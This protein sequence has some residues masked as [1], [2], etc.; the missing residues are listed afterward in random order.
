[1][2]VPCQHALCPLLSPWAPAGTESRASLPSGYSAKDQTWCEYPA[3]TF[4]PF[5]AH[6]C[7]LE[8]C[9]SSGEGACG[10]PR[11]A[12]LSG[13]VL[14][15]CVIS[16]RLCRRREHHG[17]HE[18][19][20]YYGERDTDSLVKVRCLTLQERNHKWWPHN[21]HQF[22]PEPLAKVTVT[23]QLLCISRCLSTVEGP[24]FLLPLLQFAESVVPDAIISSNQAEETREDF[25]KGIRNRAPDS[26]GCSIN[27]FVLVKK[28]RSPS[29]PDMHPVPPRFTLVLRAPD[30]AP[31]IPSPSTFLLS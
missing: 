7:A 23:G 12:F 28:V 1:V 24:C 16:V 25:V 22:H 18:H 10:E 17:H 5:A 15:P 29:T 26:L 2:V 9:R 4:G 31:S 13:F 21:K 19:E 6:P 3:P 14:L 30:P 8:A 20:S 11:S 27:G